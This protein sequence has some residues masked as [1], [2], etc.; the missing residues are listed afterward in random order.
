[1]KK[2]ICIFA[3]L[4]LFFISCRHNYLPCENYREAMR[5]FV[6]KISDNARAINPS[7]IVIPQNGQNVAWDD[8]DDINPDQN[9]F[10]AIDGCGRE[11]TFYG[12]DAN[13]DIADGTVTPA[14]L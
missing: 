4:F 10:N 12:M 8:E 9:Y 3:A 1:M 5:D 11:D 13:Y 2:T 6:I 14:N 7:F